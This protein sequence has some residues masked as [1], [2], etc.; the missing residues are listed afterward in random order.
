MTHILCINPTQPHL[1]RRELL[2]DIHLWTRMTVNNGGLDRW[3]YMLE[4]K[5]VYPYCKSEVGFLESIKVIGDQY[6][7]KD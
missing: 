6:E 2:S 4:G 1:T 5:Q 3:Y 7:R